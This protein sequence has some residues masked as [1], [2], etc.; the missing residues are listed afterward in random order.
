[1]LVCQSHIGRA[2]SRSVVQREG[3][4]RRAESAVSANR[5]RSVSKSQ[6]PRDKSG[7]RDEVVSTSYTKSTSHFSTMD[8]YITNSTCSYLLLILLCV[9]WHCMDCIH[10]FYCVLF[11][12][13]YSVNRIIYS[14]IWSIDHNVE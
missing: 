6:P 2:R 9:V 13:F 14:V 10:C 12:R 5:S 7:V 1:M 3:R 4:K 11:C 8:C